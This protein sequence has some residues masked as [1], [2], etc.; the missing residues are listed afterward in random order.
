MF[1]NRPNLRQ[2]FVRSNYCCPAKRSGKAKCTG[3]HFVST[4]KN[5]KSLQCLPWNNF[6][7][8]FNRRLLREWKLENID[9]NKQFQICLT[10]Y[11][12]MI[13]NTLHKFVLFP[14][15]TTTAKIYVHNK[16][17]ISFHLTILS[18]YSILCRFVRVGS[19]SNRLYLDA[20]LKAIFPYAV[21]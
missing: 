8:Y 4:N 9:F 11:V 15:T 5:R 20:I 3:K 10:I 13:L 12:E 14:K 17:T 6:H 19:V 18:S 16:F 1:E 21:W 7:V 2:A